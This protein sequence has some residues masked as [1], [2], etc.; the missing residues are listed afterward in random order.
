MKPLIDQSFWSDP[1]IE[2]AE[3]EVKLTALWL[4]T[5]SQT[6]LLGICGASTSRFKFET[7]LSPEALQ[8]AC[9]ALPR[10]FK[11]F[12][13]LIFVRNYVR[14]QFG[15]GEKLVKNNF[16][17]ALKSLFLGVKDQQLQSFIL[18]EYPEFQQ[19]LAKGFEGLTKPKDVKVRKEKDVKVE[20]SEEF[21]TFW[22][23][24]PNKVAKEK[25]RTSFETQKCAQVMDAIMPALEIAKASSKWTKDNGDFIPNPTT[26]INQRRW[27]S[28][29]EVPESTAA[30]LHGKEG[31]FGF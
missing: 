25:A 22:E 15:S 7:G 23:A 20:E 3:S 19:A 4:I 8:R 17:V 31:S 6:S 26:W 12:G 29:L 28:T 1:D 24:Y 11:Q 2:G 18:S 10:S 13:N 14:Y 16:F 30:A 21:L 5:N 27:E 9:E